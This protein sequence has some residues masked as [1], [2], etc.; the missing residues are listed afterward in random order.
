MMAAIN[1]MKNHT[2]GF[3]ICIPTQRSFPRSGLSHVRISLSDCQRISSISEGLLV[4]LK[5]D[6]SEI[7]H[8][9]LH[10]QIPR[11]KTQFLDFCH[12]VS[13]CAYMACVHITGLAEVTHACLHCQMT[14]ESAAMFTMSF[15]NVCFMPFH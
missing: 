4:A 8:T 13:V 2:Y 14:R 6:L 12:A 7:I 10:Y 3:M 15:L 1:T 9:C 5:L 11:E